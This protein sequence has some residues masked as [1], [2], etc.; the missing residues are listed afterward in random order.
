[1]AGYNQWAALFFI[2]PSV[3]EWNPWGSYHPLAWTVGD[4][5]SPMLFILV[6]DVL[7][8]M[9][10]KAET[11]GLLMPLV[12]RALQHHISIYADDVV[13]FLR[14]EAGDIS[15]TMGILNLLE[16]QQGSRQTYRKAAFYPLDVV[17]L[18]LQLY[19]TCCHV[20]LQVF[21]ANI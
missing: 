11:E 8:H 16:R 12:R 2:H 14:L 21:H 3:V 7:G 1:L 4:P 17:K 5:L 18:I 19:R 10:S 20:N 6:M 15:L 9:I 13:L